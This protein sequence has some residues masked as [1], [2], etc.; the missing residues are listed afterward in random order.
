[1]SNKVP[2]LAVCPHPSMIQYIVTDT[3]RVRICVDCWDF[4]PY[5]LSVPTE[6]SKRT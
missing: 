1:V 2:V 5:Q 4:I 6:T 3:V